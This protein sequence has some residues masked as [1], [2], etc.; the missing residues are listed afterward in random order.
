MKKMINLML[1]VVAFFG[2]SSAFAV[3]VLGEKLYYSGGDVTVEVLVPTAAYTSTLSLYLFASPGSEVASFG[4]NH[5]VGL[6]TVVDPST[7]GYTPGEELIFGIYVHNT[8]YSFYMGEGSRNVDG[9][10]HAAVDDL[11]GS[12]YYVG[13]EDLYGGGD[14]DYDDHRFNFSGGLTTTVPAPA[15]L[16][17]FA[18]GLIGLGASRKLRNV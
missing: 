3:P 7:L 13:F 11:G 16:M 8:G 1:L 17:I 12:S 10:M 5:Q 9:L 18:L 14:L 2:A 4:T 15:A 6:T